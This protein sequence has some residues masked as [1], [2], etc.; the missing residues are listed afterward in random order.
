LKH[1]WI[2]GCRR[3]DAPVAKAP[4]NFSQAVEEVKQWNKALT[5]DSDLRASTGSDQ[6]AFHQHNRQASRYT[7]PEQARSTLTTPAKGPL[8][9]AKPRPTAEDFRSPEL[10]GKQPTRRSVELT[11]PWL[12]DSKLLTNEQMTITGT[13]TLPRQFHPALYSYHIS[14]LKTILAAYYL[15]TVL[16]NSRLLTTHEMHRLAGMTIKKVK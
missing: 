10:A 5:S 6:G 16:N 3:S 7:V 2:V 14:N 13:M 8:S 15:L 9:L 11:S 1:N 12:I 4:A